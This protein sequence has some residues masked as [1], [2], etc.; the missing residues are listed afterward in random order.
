MVGLEQ[1]IKGN[2]MRRICYNCEHRES[3]Y[4]RKI[5]CIV[6]DMPISCEDFC[7]RQTR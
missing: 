2:K 5:K 3:C 4:G 6:E 7:E 1:C